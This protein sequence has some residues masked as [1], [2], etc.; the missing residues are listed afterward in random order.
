MKRIGNT[1]KI[2]QA[3][4][5]AWSYC[6]DYKS[7]YSLDENNPVCKIESGNDNLNAQYTRFIRFA[8]LMFNVLKMTKDEIEKN[9]LTVSSELIKNI[10]ETLK[11]AKE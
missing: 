2:R 5:K 11:L 10:N 3:K 4:F 6:S 9:N 8:P 1:M 7:V